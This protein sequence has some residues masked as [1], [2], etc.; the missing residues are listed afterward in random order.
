MGKLMGKPLENSGI[1]TPGAVSKGLPHEENLESDKSRS[2]PEL[3]QGDNSWELKNGFHKVFDGFQML[4]GLK[5]IVFK[6]SLIRKPLGKVFVGMPFSCFR[7]FP[8]G[9]THEELWLFLMR[10]T[11]SRPDPS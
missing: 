10:K 11:P 5:S 6:G 1:H 9:E 7:G 2:Q 3:T 8:H 4:S